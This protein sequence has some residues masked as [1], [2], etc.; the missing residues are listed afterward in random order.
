MIVLASMLWTREISV[1]GSRTRVSGSTGLWK[2]KPLIKT[3]PLLKLI[4]T[5]TL[6]VDLIRVLQISGIFVCVTVHE[7]AGLRRFTLGGASSELPVSQD[8][9]T[10][11]LISIRKRSSCWAFSSSRIVLQGET[12]RN[13]QKPAFYFWPFFT[14]I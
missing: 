8:T 6:T 13:E 7:H 2:P 3:D 5:Y 12:E 9:V 1:T 14:F 10:C 4:N 11:L